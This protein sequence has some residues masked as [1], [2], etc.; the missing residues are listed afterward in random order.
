MRKRPYLTIV[1]SLVG[2]ALIGL[3]VYGISTQSPNRTL[4][5][6]VAHGLRPRAP[7]A[8]MLLPQLSGTGRASLASYRGRVVVLNFWASWCEPCQQ[9][10]PLL[11][12]TQRRLLRHGGTVLGVSFRDA[13][14]DSLGFIKHYGLTYPTLDDTTGEFAQAYGTSEIPETFVLDRYGHVVAISREE[15]NEAFLASAIAR[16]S[17]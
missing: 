15:V 3:L 5:D 11:E 8:G 6:A 13:S 9:E 17:V 2:A 4:D 16:A 12:R 7:A 14:S 10:A 1:A